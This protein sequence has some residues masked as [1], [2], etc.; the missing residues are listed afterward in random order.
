MWSG[1]FFGL[2]AA[3]LAGLSMISVAATGFDRPLVAAILAVALIGANLLPVTLVTHGRIEALTP[4]GALLVPIGLLL[5]LP[6]AVLVYALGETVGVV[7]AHRWDTYVGGPEDDRIARTVLVV[8]KSIVGAVLGILAM[9]RVGATGSDVPTIVL[10]SLVGVAVSTGADSAL[11]AAVTAYVRRIS[12]RSELLRGGGGLGLVA[13]GEVVAGALTTVLAGRGTSGLLLGLALLGLLGVTVSAY[14]RVVTDHRHTEELLAFAERLQGEVTVEAVEAALLEAVQHVLPSDAVAIQEVPARKGERGWLLAEGPRSRWL[15][16]PRLVDTRD[17]EQQP[18]AVLAAAVSLA[19]VALTR[20][21]AQEHLVEQERMRSL[22]LSTVAHDLRSPLAIVRTGLD[23]LKDPAGRGDPEQRAQL[24]E[25]A[26]R[27]AERTNRLVDDLLGLGAAERGIDPSAV[28]DV[29]AAL[30]SLLA[31]LELRDVHVEL[32]TCTVAAA[33]DPVSLGRIVENLVLNAAKYSPP[34]GTI[35]VRCQPVDRS[36][37][38]VPGVELSI[39]D[40]GPGVPPELRAEVFEP[41]RHGG[42]A[43]GGVGLGLYIAAR[44]TQLHGGEIRVGDASGGGAA[45]HVWLPRAP[46]DD[47]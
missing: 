29:D 6:E 35:T 9:Q 12:F 26:R 45:F 2:L 25:A 31:E 30:R 16:I 36:A 28:T 8:G 20:A 47:Q 22:V 7:A 17:Y 11:L 5:P 24:L 3:L 38:A 41:F 37:D 13:L 40:E 14:A 10:A 43:R 15:V 44:F 46:G 19:R 39:E 23:T 21:Q 27:A 33:I 34:G 18:R 4:V 42:D 1:V 32:E